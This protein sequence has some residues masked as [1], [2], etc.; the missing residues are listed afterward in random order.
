MVATQWI[1]AFGQG[2]VKHGII[3]R[4]N[5]LDAGD[6]GAWDFLSKGKQVFIHSHFYT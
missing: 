5:A 2:Q 6:G 4:T 3:I 1:V